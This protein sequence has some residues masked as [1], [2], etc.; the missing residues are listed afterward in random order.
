MHAALRRGLSQRPICSE[1]GSI[2]NADAP[3][4]GLDRK[5]GL[6]AHRNNYDAVISSPTHG[7]VSI[8]RGKVFPNFPAHNPR[9]RCN[10]RGVMGVKAIYVSRR[11]YTGPDAVALEAI[12][13]N[14]IYRRG[15]FG[16]SVR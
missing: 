5:S 12:F 6:H 4:S 10:A 8:V 11:G 1:G 13:P 2:G 9:Y 3:Y 7:R 16:I 15:T 14:G